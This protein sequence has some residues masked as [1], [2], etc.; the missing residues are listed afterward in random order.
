MSQELDF[1]EFLKAF[2]GL[3]RVKNQIPDIKK[4]FVDQLGRRMLSFVRLAIGGSGKVKSWQEYRVG[5]RSGYAA[6]RPKKDTYQNSRN[7]EYSVGFITT[8]IEDGHHI[9][10]PSGKD[11]GY[12][13]RGSAHRANW[14]PGKHFYRDSQAAVDNFVKAGAAEYAEKI[15]RMIEM[16]MKK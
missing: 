2:E 13:Y 12:R 10:S 14:I 1:S 5:A 15:A 4:E 8:K 7:R 16:E 6:V 9:R 3:D 11:K